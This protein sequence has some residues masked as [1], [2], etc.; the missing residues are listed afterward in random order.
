MT[1]GLYKSPNRKR[2]V[3]IRN[4]AGIEVRENYNLKENLL[5]FN[6]PKV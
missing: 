1:K 5:L 4:A 3:I 6:F 2:A